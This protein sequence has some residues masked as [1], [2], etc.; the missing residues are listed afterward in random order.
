MT[1]PR[2]TYFLSC[3]LAVLFAI[4]VHAQSNYWQ[5]APGPFG[6]TSVTD[7]ERGADGWLFVATSSGI[8][9]SDDEGITWSSQSQGLSN[10]DVRDLHMLADG[11]LLAATYGSG[12]FAFDESLQSWVPAGLE[13]IY[14]SSIIEPVAGHILVASNGFVYDSLDNGKT[15]KSR[16]MDGFQVSVKSLA[17][18]ATHLFA[19]SSLGLFRSADSG[20]T[21]QF[22]SYGLDEYNVLSVATDAAGVVYAGAS[23]ANGGCALYRSRGNG[24]IWTCIQPATNPL[25]VPVLK[26]DPEGAIWA[27]GYQRLYKSTSQ[28][29]TWLSNSASTSSVQAI[30]FFGNSLVIG[31]A[32]LAV[33]RS[34][35]AGQTWT[36]SNT[37]L[38]SKI[39]SITLVGPGRIL[40]GT[41]GGVFES[42]NYGSNWSRV[43]PNAPLVQRITD[44]DLDGQ[45]RIVAATTA[46]V[47]R[48][49]SSSG[50]DALGP[51]MPS[52]RDFS[53]RP[54]GSIVAG[55]HA[56][57][58]TL[59]GTTWTPTPIY[60]ADQSIRD[61]ST[62]IVT[63]SGT[64]LAGASWDSWKKTSGNS[65]WEL[66]SAGSVPWFDVRTFG[67]VGTRVMAGTRYLGI[68]ES[69]DDGSTWKSLGIGLNGTEDILAIAADGFDRVHIATYGSG[70]FQM[71]P[72][73]KVWMPMNGGLGSHLIV[74][75]LA[76]DQVGNA[77]AGTLDGGL[78]RHVISTANEDDPGQEIPTS[79][80]LGSPYPNPAS[81]AITLPISLETAGMVHVR[82]YDLLGRERIS[83]S[84][85]RPA[86][87]W[88][89]NL[90]VQELDA[91][92]YMY[93]VQSGNEFK[94]GSFT[95]IY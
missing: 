71:N 72:W 28:G 52:I 3:L 68:L 65:P 8:F 47:W 15:W 13:R 50:W 16:T 43:N 31:T 85:F 54:D 51:G 4:P 70:V 55:Y 64:I 32:G 27:G 35:N 62:L 10:F 37:G 24:N 33:L 90:D 12:L 1:L 22:A 49:T 46:G 17:F 78:F 9:I 2:R 36:E 45:G 86:S 14:T 83:H 19:A 74:T 69:I 92:I 87:K 94:N 67:M 63:E 75:A 48:Y 84:T 5:Q 79:L 76:F 81:R 25:L 42:N 88:E 95:V 53:V 58:Y 93:S 89:F 77:Y 29:D 7:I 30:G 44:A 38:R 40:V 20:L 59:S 21:W 73:T 60:G 91:G 18:N 61:V 57:L 56:G 26:V 23:P 6:G 82:I 41:E 66:M 80:R 34:Q 11:R 39:Q